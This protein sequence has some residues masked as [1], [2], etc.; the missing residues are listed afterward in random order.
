MLPHVA[1][2]DVR[3]KCK[4]Q[5][6]AQKFFFTHF[7]TNN[8]LQQQ[9][10]RMIIILIIT[11]KL[12]RQSNHNMARVT[13]MHPPYNIHYS[14]FAN[15]YKN[16]VWVNTK[17]ALL[18]GWNDPYRPVCKKNCASRGS[19]R[20]STPPRGSDRVRTP[21]RGWQGRCSAGR[22]GQLTMS[23]GRQGRAVFTHTLENVLLKIYILRWFLKLVCNW[24]SQA[25]ISNVYQSK[26]SWCHLSAYR[27][28][29]RRYYQ[30]SLTEQTGRCRQIRHRG[31]ATN[32]AAPRCAT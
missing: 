22:Q 11:Q 17:L 15:S 10:S 23:A 8:M 13:T 25:A 28:P 12:V 6:C 5:S 31:M 4:K 18:A 14:Y 21:P 3:K 32:L 16:A 2:R 19:A 30:R 1:N 7:V 9:N 29:T 26:K 27:G 24:M 20:V